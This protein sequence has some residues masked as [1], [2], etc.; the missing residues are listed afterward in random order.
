MA[1]ASVAIVRNPPIKTETIRR[2]LHL[3][4]GFRENPI[5]SNRL[6]GSNIS[7]WVQIADPF[8]WFLT[9]TKYNLIKFAFFNC[10][11]NSIEITL[12]Q[13]FQS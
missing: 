8:F 4:L 10:F 9:E 1:I 7:K 3:I 11:E 6:N 13:C 12:K 2:F 5:K